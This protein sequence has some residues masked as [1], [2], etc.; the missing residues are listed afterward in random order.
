MTIAPNAQYAY[1]YLIKAGLTP[2]A[3]AGAV[4]NMEAESGVNPESV[5]SI[6]AIGIAQWLG[7]RQ[8]PGM[9]TGNPAVDLN[10]QLADVVTELH[11]PY[12]NVLNQIQAATSPKQ[13]ANEWG[14]GYEIYETKDPNGLS[15]SGQIRQA[16]SQEIWNAATTNNWATATPPSPA[17]N[18]TTSGNSSSGGTQA[19]YTNLLSSALSD[20]IGKGT[21]TKILLA[22]VGLILLAIGLDA[23]TK[24][25]ASPGQIIL[26]SPAT[27]QAAAS[28]IN[29]QSKGGNK[30]PMRKQS[31]DDSD[32]KK[33]EDKKAKD[34]VKEGAED[35]V[36]V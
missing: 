15:A 12:K 22:I 11:G 13:A 32:G 6:G 4:G 14:A 18:N 17:G 7:G 26:Q 8:K 19:Q 24:T 1:Q 3:A 34:D 9:Q 27:V 35:S 31:K 23:L 5:N 28:K 20:F 16:N 33:D 36:V 25:S 10:T 29:G 2:N 30:A 21:A